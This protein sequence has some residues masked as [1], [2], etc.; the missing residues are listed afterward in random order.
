MESLTVALDALNVAITEILGTEKA[1]EFLS[2]FDDEDAEALRLF[3]KRLVKGKIESADAIRMAAK[4]LFQAIYVRKILLDETQ[5]IHRGQYSLHSKHLNPRVPFP[6]GIVYSVEGR[7]LYIHR[8]ILAQV[9]ETGLQKSHAY[10]PE[11]WQKSRVEGFRDA[12]AVEGLFLPIE[13]RDGSFRNHWFG[14]EHIFFKGNH[15]YR[16]GLIWSQALT[17]EFVHYVGPDLKNPSGK[18]TPFPMTAQEIDQI[19]MRLS[20]HLNSHTGEEAPSPI[21]S[22]SFWNSAFKACSRKLSLLFQRAS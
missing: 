20:E 4:T 16:P 18:R 5:K 11:R 17:R 12:I 10:G 22:D 14:P 21:E 13:N 1:G 3:T 9:E 8:I 6:E 19:L 7:E 15:N 2:S